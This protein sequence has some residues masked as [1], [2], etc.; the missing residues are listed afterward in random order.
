MF[1]RVVVGSLLLTLS[2]HPLLRAQETPTVSVGWYN[3]DRMLGI[4][5]WSNWYVS[6]SEY[7]RVYDNFVVPDG[8]WTIAG[9]FANHSFYNAPPVTQAAWE[10]RKGMS[11]GTAGTLVA[12]GIDA[13]TQTY[14]SVFDTYSIEVAG[15]QVQLPPGIYWLNV[16]PVGP[17]GGQSY[18]A[19]TLGSNAVGNPPGNDGGA[20]YNSPVAGANFASIKASGQAGTSADFSQGVKILQGAP[21]VGAGWY[22]GDRMIGIP[23]WSNWYVS[24]SEYARVYDNFVVPN[25]GWTISGVFANHTFYNAPPVTQAAWEIRSG[26]SPG[27]GG[28]LVASGIDTATQTYDPALNTYGI[29][30]DGLQVQL[31]PG[32]YWL[33]VAP[34]GPGGGQSYV[35]ATLGANAVGN[36]PGNDG[37]AL[38]KSSGGSNFVSVK[39]SGQGGSSADFSQGVKIVTNGAQVPQLSHADQWRAD[40]ASL[41]QQMQSFHSLPFPGISQADFNA[42]V[43]DLRNR[44]PSMSDPEI[45]TALEK[46]VASIEDPH[47]DVAWP[48]PSPFLSLPLSFYWFD[49]GIYITAAAAQYQNLLGGRVTG[50]GQTG[51]G[52]ATVA[53]T[54]LVPHENDQWVKHRIPLQELTNADFL[55]GTGL[56]SDINGVPLQ[57]QTAADGTISASIPSLGNYQMPG[58][59]PVFQGTPPL[60]RQKP[61]W[62]YWATIIDGGATVY[63][64][65]NSCMEDPKQPS[66]DF[67][68]Q[69]DQLQAQ[70]GVQ[71]IILDMRNNSGGFTSILSPWIDKIQASRFNQSGRLY[72]IVGRATFSAAME[73]TNHL[74]DRTAALFVG[75]PT[76]AKPQ[77]ELRRG[78]FGLPYFGI[79]VSYSQGVESANVPDNT[80]TPDIVTGL[81]FQQYMDGVDPALDAILSIPAPVN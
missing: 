62:N 32:T 52:D 34:V 42:N 81:T 64:Q 65:Y 7:A 23:G 46:L 41:A 78:D 36:P 47:T 75:E 26:M 28:T 71:R 16:A 73:A 59:I 53:L 39:S 1:T 15:L 60:Y 68:A 8:G 69:L 70:P 31:Q 79:R 66:A 49:D 13:A 20:L 61:N 27:A 63:F 40:I 19:A 17:G 72:V 4:Q 38:Y 5:G 80:L 9:V 51:I 30:V 48:Y 55:F 10:I 57:V 22:N 77:F 25:G 37:G 74:H 11:P 45:R 54:A 67:F 24:T 43:A 6:A 76:G 44:I 33:N 3:G 35:A 14:N 2:S 29:E 12:W 18:V 58:Q 56:I 21:T 50:V